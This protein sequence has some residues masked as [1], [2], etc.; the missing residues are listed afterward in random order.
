[1][2]EREAGTAAPHAVLR[3]AGHCPRDTGRRR[4]GC[5]QQAVQLPWGCA[6]AR[7]GGDTCELP[8]VTL[9]CTCVCWARDLCAPVR[10]G[11]RRPLPPA[12]AG[13]CQLF[14]GDLYASFPEPPDTCFSR[15][16]GSVIVSEL[17]SAHPLAPGCRLGFGAQPRAGEERCGADCGRRLQ[18]LQVHGWGPQRPALPRPK[19]LCRGSWT[20]SGHRLCGSTTRE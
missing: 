6:A 9:G 8:K 17:W 16:K 12:A 18:V 14:L 1:M 19:V 2:S 11:T 20:S 7:T 10:G 15:G 13:S 5:Q 4:R 3:P